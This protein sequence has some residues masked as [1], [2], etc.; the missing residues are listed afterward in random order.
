MS[1]V[2]KNITGGYG[3]SI[4]C[5]NI[6][7][8]LQKGD[9]VCVVGPN[10]S[11]KTTLIK[12]ILTLLKKSSGEVLIN[13]QAIDTYSTK[14]LAKTIAYVPQQHSV[15][16]SLSV[17]DIVIMGRTSYIPTFSLPKSEDEKKAF[18]ALEKLGIQDLAHA[19]YNELSGGQK[20]MVLIARAICQ[21]PQILVMDEPTSSLDYYN[22]TR[23]ITTIQTLS[24]ND[25]SILVTSHNLSQPFQ[26]ANKVLML[27]KGSA[28][29]FG[30]T[31][32]IITKHNLSEVYELEMDVVSAIDS[33][34][35][36]RTFC[37]PL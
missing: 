4:V 28:F 9:V 16:F 3:K 24:K 6:S 17:L 25:F 12:L 31:E 27:K 37:I 13:N 20:Q 7:F 2:V 10:G 30:K 32:D 36:K 5:N 14:N 11:G 21:E 1:M 8:Q 22:Q 29:A 35:T 15:Q 23:V 18:E 26:Y 19:Q 33:K 34:G